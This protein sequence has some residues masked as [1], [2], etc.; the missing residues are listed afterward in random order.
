MTSAT[1]LAALLCSRLCHDLLSPVAAI[2]NGFELMADESDPEMRASCLELIENSAR[3][4]AAKLQFYRFA[5]GSPGSLG[6]S[7]PLTEMRALI[8]GLVAET[9]KVTLDW[10]DAP[11]EMMRTPVKILLGLAA[12]GAASLVRGGELTIG[13]ETHDGLSE[14][15]IR[16]S[17]PR[18]AFDPIIGRALEGAL[19]D[20]EVSAHTAPAHLLCLL[21]A[22][23]G[24]SIQ[25]AL[26]DD[27]LVLGAMLPG[28]TGMVG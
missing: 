17:G 24:G 26:T 10:A 3:S 21:A 9:G 23:L 19:D 20:S 14:I 5:Y 25:Y 11:T 12:I 2:G 6:D 8:E 18:I 1:D 15:A 27:A 4:S 7:V 22:E 13:A 28:T 16:A